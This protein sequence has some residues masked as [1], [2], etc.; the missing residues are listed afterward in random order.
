MK[1]LQM[2]VLLKWKVFASLSYFFLANLWTYTF[3]IQVNF[4][5]VELLENI[6]EYLPELRNML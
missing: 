1:D 2:S 4:N 6:T 5:T 3:Q